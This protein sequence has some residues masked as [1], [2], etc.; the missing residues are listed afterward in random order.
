M[1]QT[2]PA[3]AVPDDGEL[4]RLM[5]HRLRP[6]DN[7]A[8]GPAPFSDFDLHGAAPRP[9]TPL[10]EAAV[11][12]ALVPR[13]DGL[14]LVLTRRTEDLPT[15][16]GQIAFPGGRR[17][18]GDPDLVHTALREAHEEVGLERRWVTPL[19]LGDAYRTV[20]GFRVTPV[21]GLVDPA[22][23]FEADPREVAA[24]FEAPFRHF[25]DPAH[26]E[27][28]SRMWQG[29]E[30]RYYAMPWNGHNV[31]GATAGMLRALSLRVLSLQAV[32][33]GP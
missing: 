9:E 18:P 10:R 28:H 23:R 33:E 2:R 31:W 3:A 1:S 7:A 30:R 17:D 12:V 22:A 25:M 6:L 27:R 14:Q 13:A 32:E 21:V 26:H 15:H 29:M 5:R 4:V 11:L 16:A 24:I 8:E 19:G 20:T